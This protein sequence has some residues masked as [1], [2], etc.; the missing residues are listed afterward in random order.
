MPTAY[1][2]GGG[3]GPARPFD[4]NDNDALSKPYDIEWPPTA[5]TLQQINEM[6]DLLF[7]S[8]TKRKTEISALQAAA[9]SPII[10]KTFNLTNAQLIALS[11]LPVVL[12]PAQGPD[13]IIIP[14]WHNIELAVAVAYT[15]DPSFQP[16]F[17]GTAGLLLTSLTPTWTT[18]RRGFQKNVDGSMSYS[19]D[20]FYPKNTD[21]VL[22]A[23][24]APT[25]A[26]SVTAIYNIL[27]YVAKI[28]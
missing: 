6:F 2:P 8:I 9:T 26:G 11:T 15:S 25:G 1:T 10:M 7:K 12:V 23:S 14:V 20:G 16:G 3:G 5:D 13:T 22:K 27:Y 21:L 17:T 19:N 28:L 24:A 4:E 18:I